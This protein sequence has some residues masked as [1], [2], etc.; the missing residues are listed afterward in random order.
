MNKTLTNLDL[1]VNVISYAGATCIVEAVKV[2]KTLTNVD[3]RGNDI[4]DADAICIAEA[5]R[6]EQDANQ[7]VFA[8]E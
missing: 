2:N 3:L 1:S 5:Q 4:S 8:K 6:S 7:F